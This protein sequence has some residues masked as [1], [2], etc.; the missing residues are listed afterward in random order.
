MKRLC[1]CRHLCH[2]R[3]KDLALPNM[4]TISRFILAVAVLA[5]TVFATPTPETSLL[6]AQVNNGTTDGDFAP[7]AT[8][9]FEPCKDNNFNN[10]QLFT[11][12]SDQCCTF[13]SL[14]SGRKLRRTSG[15][16]YSP[17]CQTMSPVDGTT[18]S[19]PSES[20]LVATRATSTGRS[21]PEV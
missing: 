14:I 13:L 12:N 17:L 18:L 16:T 20:C 15:L 19:L 11:I 4:F 1:P 7:L 21:C 9:Q 5:G 6:S 2:H 10:C 3:P 8:V